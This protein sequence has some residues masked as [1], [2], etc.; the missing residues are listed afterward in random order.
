MPTYFVANAGSNSNAGTSSGSPFQTIAHALSVAVQGDTLNLNGG[1]TFSENNTGIAVGLTIQPYGTG[2]PTIAGA[3]GSNTIQF[4]NVSGITLSNLIITNGSVGAGSANV[5]FS[6]TD[7]LAHNLGITVSGCTITGGGIALQF[8]TTTLTTAMTA[9]IVIENNTVS[10]AESHGIV[11]AAVP[12]GNYCY[13]NVLIQGNTVHDILGYAT[14]GGVSGVGIEVAGADASV[15]PNYVQYN[16]VF[17]CGENAS[18]SGLAGPGGIFMFGSK[19]VTIQYNVVHDIFAST[20]THADGAAVDI[21]LNNVSCS[22]LYNYCYNCQ[23]AGL[24]FLSAAGSGVHTIAGNLVV[25]CPTL[26][27]DSDG[28]SIMQVGTGTVQVCNNTIINY[29]PHCLVSR[30]SRPTPAAARS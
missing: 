3:S 30:S 12:T 16:T 9:N 7:G 28:G 6:T 4:L 15:A 27:T 25:N 24:I 17:N 2:Q 21:D 20:D 29:G 22:L 18:G 19:F 14:T 8:L 26:A 1:D 23:G 5:L 10:G 13:S 11:T